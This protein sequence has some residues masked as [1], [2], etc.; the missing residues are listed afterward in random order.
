MTTFGKRDSALGAPGAKPT[1]GK[2]SAQPMPCRAAPSAER[3]SPQAMAFLEAERNRPPVAAAHP[4]VRQSAAAPLPSHRQ[5][6]PLMADAAAMPV[7]PKVAAP[8]RPYVETRRP[9]HHA[10]AGKPVWGR[11][12]V[13]T[14]IDAAV[15]V[16]PL[17]III[18]AMGPQPQTTDAQFAAG[19][20]GVIVF[21]SLG[22]LAYA[23]GMES[24]SLQATLGK[25]VVGAI[26]TDKTGGKPTL[27]AIIMRNTLGKLVSGLTPFYISYLMGLARKD[28]RCLH[29]LIAGTMV[30]AKG[31]TSVSYDQTFA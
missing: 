20:L 26:V 24:S 12:V 3:L 25:M 8:T 27:G 7:E 31:T 21:L 23:I 11:R 14:L 22:S 9:S 6:A 16:V 17:M 2:K 18:G 28:R 19:Y 13:A 4:P 29:D 10:Y 5:P 1:F 30:C 15:F